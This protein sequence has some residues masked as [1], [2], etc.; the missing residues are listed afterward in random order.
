MSCNP[1][2]DQRSGWKPWVA[3]GASSATVFAFLMVVQ[4]FSFWGAIGAAVVLAVAG[5]VALRLL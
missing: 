5:L 2:E 4:H 3:A 1:E